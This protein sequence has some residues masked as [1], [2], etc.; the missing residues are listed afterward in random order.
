MIFE[1]IGTIACSQ[2][3]PN[4]DSTKV[5]AL[6]IAKAAG[7]LA[8]MQELLKNGKYR[9]ALPSLASSSH[10]RD[11]VPTFQPRA[12]LP[13]NKIHGLL[14][15][16][17]LCRGNWQSFATSWMQSNHSRHKSGRGRKSSAWQRKAPGLLS[18]TRRKRYK[19]L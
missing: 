7:S 2:R 1:R 8:R 6:Q 18:T 10:P 19:A 14:R 4:G 12:M 3:A 16:L 11:S 13:H 9:E 17:P 15:L 5:E